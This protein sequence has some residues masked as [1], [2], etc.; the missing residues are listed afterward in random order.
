MPRSRENSR[1]GNVDFSLG[2]TLLVPAALLMFLPSRRVAGVSL[3]RGLALA[4]GT[5]IV[6]VV[7]SVVIP[8]LGQNPGLAL[9]IGISG[10]SVFAPIDGR[11]SLAASAIML[12]DLPLLM[13]ALWSANILPPFRQHSLDPDHPDC[14]SDPRSMG[15]ALDRA[16]PR[17][18]ARAS[19]R[20]SLTTSRRSAP[21]ATRR[22]PPRVSHYG[23]RR[24]ANHG[25]GDLTA[26]L[27]GRPPVLTGPAATGVRRIV[28]HE[29][30]APSMW[31][32]GV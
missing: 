11:I 32:T 15:L 17:S 21:S 4:F 25:R 29:D 13:R 30:V 9:L 28:I 3:V 23:E 16:S 27:R 31:F 7:L 14:S 12:V 26:H 10:A 8:W 1:L 5:L 19:R 18:S 22:E 2:V 20:L 6:L 24:F